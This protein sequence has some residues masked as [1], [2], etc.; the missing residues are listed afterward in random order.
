MQ[1][2][3]KRRLAW[4]VSPGSSRFVPSSVLI[5]RLQC[6]PEPLTPAKGFSWSKQTSPKRVAVR[7]RTIISSCWWSAATLAFSKIGANSYC[8]G[9][10]SLW[11]V[12]TGT[13]NR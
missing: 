12:A 9:A 11:R 2:N 1:K 7:W 3:R 5:E 6:L 4:G 8:P 10:T 13:P